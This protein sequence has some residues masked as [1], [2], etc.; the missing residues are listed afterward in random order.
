M[1]EVILP[2]MYVHCF[3]IYDASDIDR[4]LEAQPN[5]FHLKERESY[6][7]YCAPRELAALTETLEKDLQHLTAGLDPQV[8]QPATTTKIVKTLAKEINKRAK[9][10]HV[11][12]K[13]QTRVGEYR[14]FYEPRMCMRDGCHSW[15]RISTPEEY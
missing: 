7:T 4:R 6:C 10:E 14:E 12:I 5:K 11:K 8:S 9:D 15:Y 2:C 3:R 13:D 1:C